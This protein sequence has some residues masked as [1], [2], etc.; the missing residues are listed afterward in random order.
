MLTNPESHSEAHA[1]QGQ[2]LRLASQGYVDFA[3]SVRTDVS[4]NLDGGG[5]CTVAMS[6]SILHTDHVQPPASE[7]TMCQNKHL[8]SLDDQPRPASKLDRKNFGRR[9]LP[10]VLK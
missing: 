6:Q 10:P 9:C 7:K 3:A 8:L 4:R 5:S 2:P 1:I